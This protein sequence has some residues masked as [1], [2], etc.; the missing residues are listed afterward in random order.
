MTSAFIMTFSYLLII[1]LQHSDIY[2]PTYYDCKVALESG[3]STSGL[4]EVQPDDLEPFFVGYLI[5]DNY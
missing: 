4:Y 5:F 1:M 3:Q 2:S